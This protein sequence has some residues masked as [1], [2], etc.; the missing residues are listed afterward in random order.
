MHRSLLPGDLRLSLTSARETVSTVT[1]VSLAQPKQPNS[2]ENTNADLLNV[3]ARRRRRRA[4]L[5]KEQKKK[6]TDTIAQLTNERNQLAAAATRTNIDIRHTTPGAPFY[7]VQQC[8]MQSCQLQRR[9]RCTTLHLHSPGRVLT[10]EGVDNL[11]RSAAIEVAGPVSSSRVRER[12]LRPAAA[13]GWTLTIDAFASESNKFLPRFFARYAE[14]TAE[15]ADAFTVPD[16]VYPTCP[17]CGRCHHKTP[18]AFPPPPLLNA[19]VAMARADG[20]RAI[21]VTPLAVS[22]PYWNKLLR[23]SVVPNEEDYLRVRRQ[24]S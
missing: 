14:P 19:F 11:S 22:A 6:T 21:V 13:C 3:A 5:D 1:P 12:S 24:Q 18:F 4:A 10:D 20:V 8:A 2:N 16:W 7:P 23:S 9:L 17:S 15:A